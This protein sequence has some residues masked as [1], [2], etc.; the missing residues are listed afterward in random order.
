VQ[1]V[2]YSMHD[3]KLPSGWTHEPT[4]ASRTELL[5]GRKRAAVPHPTFDLDGDGVVGSQDLVI[6]KLFDQDHDN[7]L[8]PLE[9]SQ[10]TQAIKA[11]ASTQGLLHRFLWGVEES[12][13]TRGGRLMMKRGVIVDQEDFSDMHQTYQPVQHTHMPRC[14]TLSE[15]KALRAQVSAATPKHLPRYV[16]L[17]A[18]EPPQTSLEYSTWSQK[19]AL[20]RSRARVQIG[21][22]DQSTLIYSHQHPSL[23]Y[24]QEPK[25]RS[26]SQM[27]QEK[28]QCQLST[29]SQT[30]NFSH[31]TADQRLEARE[32]HNF[33]SRQQSRTLSALKE[34][35]RRETNEYNM[36]TFSTVVVGIHGQ[37]LPKFQDTEYWKLRPD[38]VPQPQAATRSDLL[39]Q[40]KFWTHNEDAR[41]NRSFVL[42]S[43][44]KQLTE[45]PNHCVPK[46]VEST[47]SRP[48]PKKRWTS[49]LHE[50]QNSVFS[51]EVTT[52]LPPARPLNETVDLSSD[53]GLPSQPKLS[54]LSKRS[55]KLQGTAVIRS[56]GF[57][58]S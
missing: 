6:S 28:R 23:A 8:N 31:P 51:R 46:P 30:A 57:K 29:L 50:Y 19:R 14:K 37:E 44:A 16:R 20:E 36:Q 42:G 43:K 33:V 22:T 35:R 39:K 47:Q 25:Y 7:V 26:K 41:A 40:Q 13:A 58:P 11:V 27:N 18:Y 15:L 52:T 9:R 48:R 2:V 54:I 24:I 12:G 17:E 3:V 1:L 34:V 55:K 56:S 32:V 53:Q 4:C 49:L 10:A 5:L 21:L 45:K 38:Y